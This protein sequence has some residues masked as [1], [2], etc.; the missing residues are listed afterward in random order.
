MPKIRY[1]HPKGL[2][3]ET[4]TG[5]YVG[6]SS[7]TITA[8]SGTPN[9]L[10]QTDAPVLL[11]DSANDGHEVSLPL[12]SAA[13]QVIFVLNVDSAQDAIVRNN[14]DS[15]TILTLGE[16]VGAIFVSK[17]SG[18]NWVPVGLGS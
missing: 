3:Q 17:A 7:T 10:T 6:V 1:T 2:V 14:A 5:I 9:E 16:G 4:G 12:A 18:D 15:A 13:G 8:A 11:C